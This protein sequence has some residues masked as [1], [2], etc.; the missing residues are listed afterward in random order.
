MY[1][2]ACPSNPAIAPAIHQRARGTVRLGFRRC[3]DSTV[4]GDLYQAGALKALFPRPPPD[5]APVAV[6]INTAGGV[7]AGDRLETVVHAAPGTEAVI[8]TQAAERIY[9]AL[10]DSE[11]A[12]VANRVTIDAQARVDWLPQETIVFDRARLMRRLE[13]D[14]ATDATFLGCETIVFGRAAMGETVRHGSIADLIRIRRDG[15][16]LLH[17]PLRLAGDIA[18]AL[19]RPAVAQGAN[20][21]STMTLVSPDA[22]GRLDAFRSACE[23]A[24]ATCGASAS[25]GMLVGRIVHPRTGFHR[26]AIV[27]GLAALR[28][29]RPLPRVWLT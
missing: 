27:A 2:G 4:L 11:P 28:D 5:S 3:D 12:R 19:A 1:D 6:L 14:L 8:T 7:A 13:V 26:P 17:D 25:D 24:G 29:N 21:I 22:E 20:A 10:S 15:R 16:L 9:R 18:A 23:Q